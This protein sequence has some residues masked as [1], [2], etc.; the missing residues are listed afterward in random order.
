MLG[1]KQ[2][3]SDFQPVSGCMEVNPPFDKLS[4]VEAFE[5]CGAILEANEN[6]TPLLFVVF[7]PFVANHQIIR[8]G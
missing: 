5:H 7:T 2:S 3:F 6:E 8:L 1:G 4:V